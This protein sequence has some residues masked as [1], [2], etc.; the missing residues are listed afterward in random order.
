MKKLKKIKKNATKTKKVK[1]KLKKKKKQVAQPAFILAAKRRRS[2]DI[3]IPYSKLWICKIG[4]ARV[5]FIKGD[6][7]FPVG[8]IQKKKKRR[9]DYLIHAKPFDSTEHE[10]LATHLCLI[11]S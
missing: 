7:L 10:H 11:K 8:I 5:A 4:K 1:I 3:A 6:S 2:I 9:A